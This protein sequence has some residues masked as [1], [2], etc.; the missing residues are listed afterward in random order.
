MDV[1]C[2]FFMNPI[3]LLSA[4]FILQTFHTVFIILIVKNFI[5]QSVEILKNTSSSSQKIN[6]EKNQIGEKDSDEVEFS[7]DNPLSLPSNV[8]YEIEGGETIA[9]PGFT[10]HE[11]VENE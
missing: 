4:F 9:P 6:N 3:L 5:K 2:R 11:E 1:V 10:I 8:K 7:E